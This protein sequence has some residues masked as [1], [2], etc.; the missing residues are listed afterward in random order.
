MDWLKKVH[1]GTT[2]RIWCRTVLPT[3]L[4]FLVAAYGLRHTVRARLDEIMPGGS[5]VFDE[6]FSGGYILWGAICGV[7]LSSL[8]TVIFVRR[9]LG[10]YW[11][12]I[13]VT[14]EIAAGDFTVRAGQPGRSTADDYQQLAGSVNLLAESLERTDKLRREL[15]SNLAHEIRTPLTNLQGYLEA[16]RDGVIE[17]NH[18]ALVSVHE[19]V[20]R[21]VRLVDALHQLARADALRR[22][23]IERVR[24]DLTTMVEQLVRVMKPNADARRIRVFVDP[25]ETR[26][27]VPVHSDSIAQVMRNLLRNAV[28]YCEEGG[29]IRVQST[30]LEGLYRFAVLNTGPGISDEDLPFI[31]NRFFRSES[32]RAGVKTGVGIGLAIA[33]ELIEA[34]GGRIGAQ[35]KAGWTMV[36][37]EVPAAPGVRLDPDEPG[38]RV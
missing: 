13:R 24:T 8:L 1:S 11:N 19:E 15:V 26:A 30:L 2:Y 5:H 16:L 9:L 36:W 32:A 17:A 27:M 20:M 10:P 31:F 23:P 7:V 14:R 3:S 18:E 35:S 21:L 25:G 28:Q 34:H 22:M 29:T 37:F 38:L 4:I 6:A 33:K 12:I